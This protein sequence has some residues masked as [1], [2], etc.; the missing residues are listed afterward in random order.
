MVN[1]I[2][3]FFNSPHGAKRPKRVNSGHVRTRLHSFETILIPIPC[4]SKCDSIWWH[5]N[6]PG[7]PVYHY[8]FVPWELVGRFISVGAL[9]KQGRQRQL[10]ES[11]RY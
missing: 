7:T 5:K 1:G 11:N 3:V 6:G 8:L 10:Q 9:G 4:K 2:F